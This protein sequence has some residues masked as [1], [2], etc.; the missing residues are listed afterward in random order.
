MKTEIWNGHSIRFVEK[1]SGDWWAVLSDVAK[2][3]Y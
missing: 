1:E 3:I 2:A